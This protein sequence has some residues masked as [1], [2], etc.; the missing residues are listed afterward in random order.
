MHHR[1]GR[2]L[3]LAGTATDVLMIEGFC[4]FLPEETVL[5][6][7]ELG[8]A[9]VSTIAT[10]VGE[11]QKVAGKPEYSKGMRALPEGLDSKVTLHAVTRQRA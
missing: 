10:A 3:V 6:A 8:L 7:L 4:D 11:W 2:N 9:A 5:E 1:A